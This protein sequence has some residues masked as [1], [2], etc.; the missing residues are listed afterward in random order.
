M[1][2]KD[3]LTANVSFFIMKVNSVVILWSG[4]HFILHSLHSCVCCNVNGNHSMRQHNTKTYYINIYILYI[5]PVFCPVSALTYKHP[6]FQLNYMYHHR[7]LYLQH[8]SSHHYKTMGL[9]H[10]PLFIPFWM[11]WCP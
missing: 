4:I 9:Y 2:L 6:P 3:K 11:T 7:D 10:L 1:K 5:V 8:Y